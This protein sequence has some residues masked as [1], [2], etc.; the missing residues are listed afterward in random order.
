MLQQVDF[1]RKLSFHPN[2]VRFIGACCEIPEVRRVKQLCE[3]TESLHTHPIMSNI[4][5]SARE[6]HLLSNCMLTP[7]TVCKM[8]SLHRCGPTMLLS[9]AVIHDLLALPC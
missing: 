2:V 8:E 1:Q 9:F 5:S 7:P 4:S 3:L 6:H